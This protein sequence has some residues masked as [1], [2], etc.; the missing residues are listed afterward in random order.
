MEASRTVISREHVTASQRK[1]IFGT[2]RTGEAR[3]AAAE[4]SDA[5]AASNHLKRPAIIDRLIH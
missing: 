3:N 4:A 5:R 1:L 2:G